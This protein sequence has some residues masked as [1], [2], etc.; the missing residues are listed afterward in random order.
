MEVDDC[1]IAAMTMEGHYETWEELADTPLEE[2]TYLGG[3][4][5]YLEYCRENNITKESIQK[6][7]GLEVCDIME[8]LDKNKSIP[9]QGMDC[10]LY[11]SPDTMGALAPAFSIEDV[12]KNGNRQVRH[13]LA[14]YAISSHGFHYSPSENKNKL[15][16]IR[17]WLKG[18]NE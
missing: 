2:I 13:S 5:T 8:R 16:T 6:A 3:L 1:T 7:V 17:E 9:L 12:H 11:T 18:V 14:G 4:E 15:L 10:L